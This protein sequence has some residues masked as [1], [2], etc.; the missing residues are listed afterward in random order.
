V[1]FVAIAAGMTA[2]AQVPNATDEQAAQ[3]APAK[4]AH[5]SPFP[6]T[7]QIC[8]VSK[9]MPFSATRISTC[10]Q[11]LP[12]GTH[13]KGKR[14][15]FEWRDAEGRTR[16]EEYEDF[17]VVTKRRLVTVVDPAKHVYW[18]FSIGPGAD[19]TAILV[20]YKFRNET[21]LYP[22]TYQ[23][24]P[25]GSTNRRSLA[26]IVKPEGPGYRVEEL[27]DSYVNDVWCE[28]ER[29]EDMVRP[30]MMNNKSNHDELVVT[31]DWFSVDLHEEVLW[32]MD[33]P[34][35]GKFRNEL[36]N[37][38]RSDPDP[39]LFEPPADYA[40]LDGTPKNPV[41]APNPLI[42]IPAKP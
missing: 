41:P 25:D 31:E 40:V 13:V 4:P 30:G 38:D 35:L 21:V 33:D 28:G 19:K 14:T 12:D 1:V 5:C 17:P 7:E 20:H 37:I 6:H 34:S 24:L 2:V 32:K 3:Q 15:T 27:Q 23:T 18:T 16:R 10:D 29:M 9:D 8:I 22:T 42:V 36:K 11:A 39:A 26:R